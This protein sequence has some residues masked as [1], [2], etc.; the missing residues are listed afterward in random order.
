MM[1][2]ILPI[3][4]EDFR[5]RIILCIVMQSKGRYRDHDAL[6]D[7]N[8]IVRNIFVAFSLNPIS[9]EI[10]FILKP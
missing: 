6:L 8:T 3:R 1:D 2:C 9:D 5:F 4:I 10:S 7:F